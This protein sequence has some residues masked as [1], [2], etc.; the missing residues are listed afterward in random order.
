MID[1]KLQPPIIDLLEM[2]ITSLERR[3]PKTLATDRQGGASCTNL[4][5]SKG[6]V[7]SL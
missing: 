1:E 5:T 4:A 6:C 7:C 3:Y 2:V